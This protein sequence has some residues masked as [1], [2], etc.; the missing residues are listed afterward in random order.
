MIQVAPRFASPR[1]ERHEGTDGWGNERFV[2]SRLEPR[3][4]LIDVSAEVLHCR[5]E[6][7][8]R[9]CADCWRND[10][11]MRALD[12]VFS[13]DRRLAFQSQ[14]F[15]LVAD[16]NTATDGSLVIELN[17]LLSVARKP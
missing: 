2:R 13:P 7:V 8:D 9:F 10:P 5:S 14:L 15:G 6:S 3:A 17:Y 1:E 11:E 4:S 16:W 12:Q